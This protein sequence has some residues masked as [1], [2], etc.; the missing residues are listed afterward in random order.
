MP[1]NYDAVLG[2]QVLCMTD[3]RK[4][5]DNPDKASKPCVYIQDHCLRV[6]LH[7][8]ED[9]MSDATERSHMLNERPPTTTHNKRAPG[10][11]M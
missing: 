5:S 7:D 2:P 8:S 6:N 9:Q 4:V 11:K 10:G 1:M 3:S